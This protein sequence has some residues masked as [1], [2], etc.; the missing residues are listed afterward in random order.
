M[1]APVFPVRVREI[2]MPL[3]NWIQSLG[4]SS[5]HSPERSTNGSDAEHRSS[6]KPRYRIRRLERRIVLNATAELSAFGE[7]F[8][9]GDVENDLIDVVTN[10]TGR[11]EILDANNA[12]V[13][14]RTGTDVF[15]NPILVDSVDPSEITSGSLKVDLGG[16]DDT[17]R[18]DLP[19]G[20]NLTVLDSDGNDSVEI[21]VRGDFNNQADPVLNVD[22]ESIR[23]HA[24]AN[25]LDLSMSTLRAGGPNGSVVIDNAAVTNLGTIQSTGGVNV[26]VDGTLN[27][28][29]IIGENIVLIARGDA[30]DLIV[31]DVRV[32]DPAIGD[33]RLTAGDDIRGSGPEL[34]ADDLILRAANASD[35]GDVAVQLNTNVN[36]LDAIVSGTNPGDLIINESGS[37]RLASSDDLDDASV[38]ATGNGTIRIDAND[39]ISIDDLDPTNDGSSLTGDPEII[40]SGER[41]RIDLQS[42]TQ[43]RF[44]DSVQL[45]ASDTSTGSVTIDATRIVIGKDFEINTGDG[46]GI[47]RQFAPR[48][49]LNSNQPGTAFYDVGSVA[50]DVLSQFNDNDAIG[51]LSVDIGAPGENGLSLWIDWGAST[52]R[53][54][55]VPDLPG[56]GTRVDVQH[57][58]T[59]SDLLDSKLNGRGSATDPLAVR[60]A[61]SQHPSIRLL[62]GTIEQSLTESVPDGLISRTDSG[63]AFFVI[64]RIDIPVAFFP[65]RD[66]IP[67]SV[68]PPPPIA[69]TIAVSLS[70]IQLDTVEAS[71]T[72]I[73][74][75]E[76]YFQLRVLSPDPDGDDLIEPVRLPDGVLVGDRLN[77]LFA[78]LPDGSYEIQ[79]VIG[80]GDER[81]ILRVELR[82]GEP[83]ILGDD[84]ESDSLRL[85]LIEGLEDEEDPAIDRVI[86]V[87][88]DRR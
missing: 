78:E 35:D 47:A 1:N 25:S 2:N 88:E 13:P 62:G 71:A 74:I 5:A 4:R 82:G 15:G 81:T 84:L 70:N 72:S 73:T 41:G 10:S 56:D 33:V 32:N 3:L 12:V 14:I 57:V 64:P 60:F 53:F 23:I 40:A 87:R 59:Q 11:I 79:Y 43:V 24:D 7:L 69:T 31:G 34:V 63:R 55:N 52:N 39:T 65:S 27:T 20:L 21:I 75:R 48:P 19:S 83:I 67:E 26:S 29:S 66:V 42:D 68:D 30:S 28:G 9:T 49:D 44:G 22:S 76:E 8:I 85:Q 80:D 6:S 51:T 86:P 37:I 17:L 36:D 16:G 38:V 45:D 46:V 77:R 58:Y 18:V 50:T 61:V 54:L